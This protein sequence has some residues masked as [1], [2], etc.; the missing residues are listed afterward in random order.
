MAKTKTPTQKKTTKKSAASSKTKSASAK[1]RTAK[2]ATTKPTTKT[3]V[4]KGKT[5]KK[6]GDEEVTIDRRRNERRDAEVA[7]ENKAPVAKSE[8]R[9]K[10]QRRRQIDP[11]TCE[12]DYSEKEVEFM[13]A[14][15]EYKRTSGR[16]FPTCSEVLEVI[17][18]LG[19]EKVSAAELAQLGR[20]PIAAESVVEGFDSDGD[21]SSVEEA[22]LVG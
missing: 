12:R 3:S 1:K 7:A 10:V 16:M 5:A 9:E 8:R 14:M 19:Y 6:V 17:F 20:A 18:E 4:A 22:E 2:K 11:T 15:D 13:N 21:E